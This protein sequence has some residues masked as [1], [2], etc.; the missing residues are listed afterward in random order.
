SGKYLRALKQILETMQ[1]TRRVLEN[2]ELDSQKCDQSGSPTVKKTTSPK[3]CEPINQAARPTKMATETKMMT[4]KP[5]SSPRLQ[6]SKNGINKPCFQPKQSKVRASVINII[7]V[8]IC[9]LLDYVASS[10]S[11]V[12][13]AVT[14]LSCEVL[15]TDTTTAFNFFTYSGDGFFNKDSASVDS[16]LKA[17][18]KI[19]SWEVTIL[20]EFMKKNN[21][22]KKA[23]G[24]GKKNDKKRKALGKGTTILMEFIRKRLKMRVFLSFNFAT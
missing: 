3:R 9:A 14:A 18:R 13:D 2:K 17:V 10:L 6:K 11:K 22:K 21:K 4:E 1:T 19:I 20:M 12:A 23:A 8:A 16:D 24:K 15:K 5:V 7:I